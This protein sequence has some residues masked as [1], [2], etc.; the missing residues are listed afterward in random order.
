MVKNQNNYFIEIQPLTPETIVDVIRYMN[1]RIYGVFEENGSS[2]IHKRLLDIYCKYLQLEDITY[3]VIEDGIND[4]EPPLKKAKTVELN[5]SIKMIPN[6]CIITTSKYDQLVIDLIKE[7]PAKHRRYNMLDKSWVINDKD[8]I[9]KFI[10][11]LKLNDIK[12]NILI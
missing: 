9:D 3:S 6:E 1:K 10:E 12:F 2:C 5:V 11:K 4:N 7:S 8:S